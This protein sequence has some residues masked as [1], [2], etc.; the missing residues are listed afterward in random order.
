[1]LVKTSLNY[2]PMES[3][4]EL[5]IAAL[6]GPL[7]LTVALLFFKSDM[8]APQ[9]IYIFATYRKLHECLPRAMRE[10]NTPMGLAVN[11]RKKNMKPNLEATRRVVPSADNIEESTQL[12]RGE[13]EMRELQGKDGNEVEMDW[14]RVVVEAETEN[15]TKI[16]FSISLELLIRSGNY[17]MLL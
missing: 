14:A 7:I 6:A 4:S 5:Y 3:S 12:V 15:K 10:R 2:Y 16:V 9:D 8:D 11:Q 1:M 17:A 13:A